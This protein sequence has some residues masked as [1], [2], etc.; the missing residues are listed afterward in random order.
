MQSRDINIFYVIL[1]ASKD[2]AERKK[3]SKICA[4]RLD[5]STG[6]SQLL[7]LRIETCG[8]TFFKGVA[9]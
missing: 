9:T 5:V 4:L 2:L 3:I 1:R 7:C 8:F 6:Y